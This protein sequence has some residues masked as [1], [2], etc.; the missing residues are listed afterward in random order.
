[1]VPEVRHPDMNL[2]AEYKESGIWKHANPSAHVP[3]GEWWD[4]FHDGELDS[5]IRR[6]N[7]SNQSLR[8]A[9]ATAE[10]AA[11]LLKSAKLS[12]TPT[13]DAAGGVTRSG[14]GSGSGASSRGTSQNAGLVFGWELDLWGRLRHQ[15]RGTYADAEAA[16]SDVE[17]LKLSLQAQ[18]AQAYFALRGVDA[19]RDLIESQIE[20][21]RKSLDLTKNRYAEGVASRGDVAQAESQLASAQASAI[22]LGVQRAT[23]EHSLAVLAGLPPSAL[24]LGKRTLA[25]RV[26]R[27][28]PGMPSR[29][30]ERRPDIASAERR[31]ASANERI[32]AAKAAFFPALS[33]DAAGGWRGSSG[34]FTSPNRYWSLGPTLAS[35]I[36]D[37]GQRLAEKAQADASYDRTVADYR[38]AVLTA[39]QETEDALST[40][41]ILE[42][43]AAVQKDAVR[44][45]RE[46]ERITLNQYKA[47]T[48]SYLNVVIV[49]AAALN[50]ERTSIQLQARRL[51][52]AVSLIQA[53]G[54][55]W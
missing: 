21:Y 43:E 18:T 54:G 27:V 1:M 7:V 23:L 34:L 45:A 13:L 51:N 40:L 33:L 30:L 52:A 25:E 24:S 28:S 47:G 11:A 14:G 53:L 4:V 42:Q 35:P 31:V 2:P 39:M 36:L 16:A 20:G 10:E 55:G 48:A 38:Q 5:L 46:S 6:V 49:Q 22:D 32:G 37:R 8:S 15:A 44:A 3:R 29:L 41:R 9:V 19:E 50:A 26:P 17:S 12:L